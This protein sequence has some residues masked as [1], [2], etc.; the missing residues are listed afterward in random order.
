MPRV[1]IGYREIA[2]YFG[3]LADGFEALGTK[4]SF[5]ELDRHVF[6][7]SQDRSPWIIRRLRRSLANG[8]GR[9]RT[10]VWKA[11]A[12]AWIVLRHKVIIV[13][14]LE[15]L[16]ESRP[17]L[18][19]RIARM[20][21]RR[22]VFV[23]TGSESR[24]YFCDFHGWESV[25]GNIITARA[26]CKLTR[27]KASRLAAAENCADAVVSNPLSSQYCRKRTCN[28]YQIGF[29]TG[30]L[31]GDREYRRQPSA[32]CRILH[33]PS[34]PALKGSDRIR[35]AIELLRKEGIE[36]EYRELSGVPHAQVLEAL[37]WCDLVIDQLYSDTPMAGLAREAA[38]F[39]KPSVVG[40]YGWDAFSQHVPE[41]RKP[42]AF[43]CAPEQLVP[44]VRGL[45]REPSSLIEMGSRAQEFVRKH[46]GP[47]EVADRMMQ[48]AMGTAPEDWQFEPGDVRYFMGCGVIPLQV[49]TMV[50]SILQ[51]GGEPDLRLDHSP[52]TREGLCAFARE[53]DSGH[54]GT[55]LALE[56]E[57]AEMDRHLDGV[58]AEISS[59]D[60]ELKVAERERRRR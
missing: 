23:L 42:P 53:S 14:S 32:P 44:L 24:P 11:L 21:G 18:E 5:C 48:L 8:R 15:S 40:G 43:Q 28:F 51:F 16:F 47:R 9:F 12:A 2:G 58:R 4:V 36:I 54:L 7:Y 49:R 22:V 57:I 17:F 59:L 45:L 50:R 29:P 31:C 19:F 60:A 52:K 46:W 13:S 34:H 55:I 6:E 38:V 20:L 3:N 25:D 35:S 33:S 27:E 1:F 26:L 37:A 10:R 39:G 30:N 56:D 41:D